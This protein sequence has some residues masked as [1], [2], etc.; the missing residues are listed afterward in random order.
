M[1]QFAATIEHCRAEGYKASDMR[2]NH[3]ERLTRI[4]VELE[5]K[6][7]QLAQ[8]AQFIGKLTA[9]NRL[10]KIF[11]VRL[12]SAELRVLKMRISRALKLLV[13]Y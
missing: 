11:R 1:I 4:Q 2:S 9:A 5:R 6:E 13:P 7:R 10:K 8:R 3:L 12:L